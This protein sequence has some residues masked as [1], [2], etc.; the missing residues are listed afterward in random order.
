MADDPVLVQVQ[1]L[2]VPLGLRARSVEL[3]ND[4]VRELTLVSLGADRSD[5]GVPERL[6]RVAEELRDAYGDFTAGPSRQFE[7]ALDS[8]LE[9]L[10]VTY[11]VPAHAGPF[12]A[13]LV[14]AFEDAEDFTR[15]GRYLLSLA[16]TPDV[17]A[18]RRW[19][20]GEF[21]RQTAGHPPLPWSEVAQEDLPATTDPVGE[22]APPPDDVTP[23]PR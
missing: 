10:D 16:A 19:S 4:L 13:R 5:A 8:G 3:G 18:Y 7:E 2:G 1:L 12:A 17:V 9:T 21:E 22:D 11:A 20:L 15:E 6:L 14:Q 23:S